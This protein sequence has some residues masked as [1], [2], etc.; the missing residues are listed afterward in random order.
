MCV[1]VV[2][3]G[4]CG[5]ELC[6]GTTWRGG[7][8]TRETKH[9]GDGILC[10]SSFPFVSQHRTNYTGCALFVSCDGVKLPLFLPLL[11]SGSLA[12]CY[13]GQQHNGKTATMVRWRR[14][15]TGKQKG[16]DLLLQCPHLKRVPVGLFAS[17]LQKLGVRLFPNVHDLWICMASWPTLVSGGRMATRPTLGAL[18]ERFPNIRVLRVLPFTLMGTDDVVA[19][20][21]LAPLPRLTTLVFLGEL[22]NASLTQMVCARARRGRGLRFIDLRDTVGCTHDGIAALLQLGTDD[23][24]WR[25]LERLQLPRG[26]DARCAELHALS[27]AVRCDYG[28][29]CRFAR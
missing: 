22:N 28:D 21:E 12:R 9:G 16:M 26:F 24:D 27:A 14:R 23:I 29:S 1:G 2:K 4:V 7:G 8:L 15:A 10:T 3:R 18:F 20:L 19:E 25:T 17:D 11:L 13:I 6:R 5:A